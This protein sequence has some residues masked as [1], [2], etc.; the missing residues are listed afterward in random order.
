MCAWASFHAWYPTNQLL[1]GLDVTM[2]VI[3]L[4]LRAAQ[5]TSGVTSATRCHMAVLGRW[6]SA[7]WCYMCGKGRCHSTRLE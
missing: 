2:C 4:F 1:F 6:K 7:G 3:N 5:D